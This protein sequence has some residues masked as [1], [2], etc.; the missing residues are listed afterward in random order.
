[1]LG[2]V[3]HGAAAQHDPDLIEIMLV[4]RTI[5]VTELPAEIEPVIV[6]R[7]VLARQQDLAVLQINRGNP[8]PLR[9]FE[10]T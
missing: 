1:L 8:R 4:A 5:E 7:I 3:I 9:L 6:G 2:P 10:M